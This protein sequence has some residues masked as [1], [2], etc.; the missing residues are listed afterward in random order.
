MA[1][2]I[3]LCSYTIAQDWVTDPMGSLEKAKEMGYEGME[4]GIDDEEQLFID[5]R[6]KMKELELVA[7]G[8]HI[9]IDD[10]ISRTDF[11]LDR[12][13]Q[14]D[15]K[16]LGLPWLADDCLPGGSRY[17]ETKS[18]I[19]YVIERCKQEDIIYHYHNHNF[20][21]EKINGVCKQDILLQDIPNLFFQLDVCWC[22]VSG[23]DPATYIHHYGHRISVLHMKDFK[24]TED[25]SQKKLF[26]LMGQNDEADAD[27]TRNSSGFEFQPV[28]LGQVNVPSVLN[29]AKEVGV[30]WLGVEQDA[31]L[32]R[33]PMEA[34]RISI[35]NIKNHINQ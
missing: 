26:D 20:E 8:T 24:A 16:Y 22:T 2:K 10:M 32:D 12:M 6:D 3:Y 28:G 31:S 14:M 13:K 23:Q 7:I 9:H 1:A 19:R 25:V 30:V 21:F 33:P 15:M 18:K 4:I 34:A 17:D 11:Y 29:A 35:E 27:T 5:I